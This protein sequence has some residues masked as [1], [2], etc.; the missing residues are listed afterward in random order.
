MPIIKSAKKR[1]KITKKRT[2]RNRANK[3]ALRTA[4]KRFERA[5]AEGDLEKAKV[6]LVKAQSTI[7]K[8]VKKGIIHKNNAARKKSRLARMFNQLAANA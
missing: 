1:V 8:S 4:I 7:D 5:V 3:S 2:L 6:E